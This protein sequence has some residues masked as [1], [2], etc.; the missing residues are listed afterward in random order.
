MFFQAA[1]K[2]SSRI[3]DV[4]S[5][6]MGTS[7]KEISGASFLLLVQHFVNGIQTNLFSTDVTAMALEI[8]TVKV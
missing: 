7:D 5:G 2:V 1:L 8:V 6:S 3:T 4:S